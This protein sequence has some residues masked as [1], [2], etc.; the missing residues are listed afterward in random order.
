MALIPTKNMPALISYYLGVASL[1]PFLGCALAIPALICGVI[2]V[3][4]A[5]SDKE[6]GGM[7]HAITGIVLSVIG[8]WVVFG[9]FAV[10]GMVISMFGGN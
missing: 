1:I 6:A 8:P 7:G 10:A 2:G 9:L 3:L 4:K 5:N